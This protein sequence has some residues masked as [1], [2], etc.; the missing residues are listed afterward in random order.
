MWTLAK[1]RLFS[2]R[3]YINHYFILPHKISN[4]RQHF[5]SLSKSYSFMSII[6]PGS[7]GEWGKEYIS[8]TKSCVCVFNS[9]RK[10]MIFE[11]EEV[12]VKIHSFHA[13]SFI[14]WAFAVV[15]QGQPDDHAPISHLTCLRTVSN[16]LISSIYSNISHSSS[17]TVPGTN[18]R[19]KAMR[20]WQ[21]LHFFTNHKTFQ[22]SKWTFF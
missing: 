20:I 6:T 4:M 21:Y 1:H 2:P 10:E 3:A 11:S 5:L 8:V 12:T 19:G 9:H 15:H 18:S 13:H 14:S 17:L 16:F 7:L 22:V